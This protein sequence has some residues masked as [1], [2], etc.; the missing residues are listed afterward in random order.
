MTVFTFPLDEEATAGRA[1]FGIQKD[2]R[3]RQSIPTQGEMRAAYKCLTIMLNFQKT[4]SLA[5]RTKRLI[6][7]V[8]VLD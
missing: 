7:G 6:F 2:S 3:I 5:K 4:A 8:G 1:F